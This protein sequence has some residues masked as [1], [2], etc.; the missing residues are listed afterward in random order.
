LNKE[1]AAEGK[2]PFQWKSIPQGAATSV[3][4]AIVA[5]P[6]EIGGRY[7]ENCRVGNVVADNVTISAISEGVRAYALDESNAQAL[8]AK[9]EEM[10]DERF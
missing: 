4:T 9:S 5:S 3:W 8:W 2:P 6:E 1:L 7:C 10:V